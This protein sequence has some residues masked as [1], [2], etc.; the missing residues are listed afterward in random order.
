MGRLIMAI[1]VIASLGGCAAQTGLS[2]APGSGAPGSCAPGY[3][4]AVTVFT[5]FFGRAIPGRTDLTDDE[6]RAFLDTTVT[7]AL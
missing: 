5:L 2:R 7:P 4:P 6:W 1:C 3:G